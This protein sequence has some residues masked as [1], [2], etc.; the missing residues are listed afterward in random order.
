MRLFLLIVATAVVALVVL[1]R[2]AAPDAWVLP[3]ETRI[4]LVAAC[5]G[6][7][8]GALAKWRRPGARWGAACL[9]ALAASAAVR[10]APLGLDPDQWH[11]REE[12][13][14]RARFETI[15]REV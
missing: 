13:L 9:L 6:V 11:A 7:A 4:A 12:A 2:E 1:G 15:R 10:F 8:A 3:L 5:L 14:D